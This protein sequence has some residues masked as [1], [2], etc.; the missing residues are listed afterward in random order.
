MLIFCADAD[1]TCKLI[2]AYRVDTSASDNVC[3]DVIC[4]N[5]YG[6]IF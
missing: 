5:K 2:P 1:H 6:K 4:D 3:C